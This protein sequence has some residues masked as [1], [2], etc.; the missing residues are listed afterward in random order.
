MKAVIVTDMLYD[1]I[2]GAL[3]CERAVKIIKPIQKLL[4]KA[5]KEKWVICYVNDT[6]DKTDRELAIWGEHAM[7]GSSGNRVIDELKPINGDKVFEKHYYSA[8]VNTGLDEYLKANNVDEIII[9]GVQAHICVLNTSASAY[10]LG[11]K[12][13]AP[14][15]CIEAFDQASYDMAMKYISDFYAVDISPIK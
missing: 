11:Y 6:H 5:H 3:K 1:F 14:S 7:R 2:Y 8:F 12:I 4:E 9:V 10:N 13:K 15:N